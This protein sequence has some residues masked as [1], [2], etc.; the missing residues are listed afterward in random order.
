MAGKQAKLL[1]ATMVAATMK[2]VRSKRYPVGDS[3]MLLLS[4]KAGLRAGEIAKLTW[5]IGTDGKKTES[6]TYKVVAMLDKR[7]DTAR[8]SKSDGPASH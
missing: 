2:H 4:V 7:I 5:P 8:L 6:E 3:V 1:T